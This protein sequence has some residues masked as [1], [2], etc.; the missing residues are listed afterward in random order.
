LLAINPNS[1]QV[2]YWLGSVVL[3]QGDPDKNELALFSFA[4]AAAYEGEGALNPEGRKQVDAYLTK[5]YTKYAGTETGLTE[6]KAVAKTQPLPPP[7]LKIESADVRAFKAE[8]ES[9]QKNPL[10]WRFKD[11]KATLTG[12]NGDS[13]WSDLNGK[14]TPQMKLYVVSADPP[15]R[16]QT[17]NLSS[18]KGGSVEVILNLENRSRTAIGAGREVTFEGVAAGLTKQPF[19]LTVNDGKVL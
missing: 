3:A 15:E 19:R 18:E 10:L 7:G 14:L 13:T 8:Q 11:L 6:L 17:L 4:R 1:A 2:S 12:P 9:R 16:P 5:V